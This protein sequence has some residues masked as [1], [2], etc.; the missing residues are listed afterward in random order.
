MICRVE[1]VDLDRLE[2][3]GLADGLAGRYLSTTKNDFEM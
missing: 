1:Q 3:Y 2:H